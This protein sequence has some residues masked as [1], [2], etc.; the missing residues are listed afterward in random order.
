MTPSEKLTAL[1]WP[2]LPALAKNMLT[3][4]IETMD[5]KRGELMAGNAMHLTNAA[6]VLAVG[7]ACFKRVQ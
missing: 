7:L 1:G 4:P 5:V 6:I 3:T 2:T